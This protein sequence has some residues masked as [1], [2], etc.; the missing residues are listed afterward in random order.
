MIRKIFIGVCLAL[1]TSL[2]IAQEGKA[3]LTGFIVDAE[4]Y[5]PIPFATII[6]Y[7]YLEDSTLIEVGG[8]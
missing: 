3:R 8:L 6:L 1:G 5:T 2:G 4:L 7:K